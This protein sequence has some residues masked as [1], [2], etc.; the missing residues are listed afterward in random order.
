MPA[1]DVTQGD[2]LWVLTQ[3]HH[4]LILKGMEGNLVTLEKAEKGC[5]H[6]KATPACMEHVT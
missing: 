3:H 1:S 4:S 5:R 6:A 2:E